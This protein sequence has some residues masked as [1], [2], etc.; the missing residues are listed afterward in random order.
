MAIPTTFIRCYY[1][2][3]CFSLRS[4][5]RASTEVQQ[6]SML[7]KQRRGVRLSPTTAA[8]T[9]PS[10]E[11]AARREET[12]DPL[13]AQPPKCHD[14][15]ARLPSCSV[16][17]GP[18]KSLVARQS[19][20]WISEIRV[21]FLHLC[22]PEP[23]TFCCVAFRVR[24]RTYVSAFS[25]MYRVPGRS[26]NPFEP[27]GPRSPRCLTKVGKAGGDDP[28]D[29]AERQQG[30]SERPVDE[31]P[32]YLPQTQSPGVFISG[33]RYCTERKSAG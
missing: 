14:L 17:N 16:L 25:P 15:S 2:Q 20:G 22:G 9:A 28:K 3:R 33:R 10:D 7:V 18:I 8:R 5:A 31:E 4:I 23:V 30:Q 13:P 24:I 1:I 12:R 19:R 21:T 26:W 32:T 29:L 6:R 27:T 11:R